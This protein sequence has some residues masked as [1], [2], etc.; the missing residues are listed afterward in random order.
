MSF[1]GV[2]PGYSHI[3][4]TAKPRPPLKVG[5]AELKWYDLAS[6]DGV[7]A[8]VQAAAK[9][10]LARAAE[11]GSLGF[12]TEQDAGFV[13]LHRCGADF[14]FLLT[15]IWRGSN[16][17]WESVRYRHGDMTDFAAFDPAYP[18]AGAGPVRAAFCVWELRIVDFEARAWSTY[19]RSPRTGAD[20][21][22]WRRDC[23]SGAV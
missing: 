8:D 11:G 4:K 1:G 17:L 21:D 16:E 9:A 19:L 13:I 15:S 22:A 14:Y 6:Q 5:S 23:F 2:D 18:P 12:G 10:H 3:A 20:Q 7:P